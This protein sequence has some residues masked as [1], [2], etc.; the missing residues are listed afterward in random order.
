M[1]P[2]TASR[3][4][5]HDGATH[6]MYPRPMERI[7]RILLSAVGV[8]L[9][10]QTAYTASAMTGADSAVGHGHLAQAWWIASLAGL[11]GLARSISRSLKQRAHDPGNELAVFGWIAGGYVALELVER[12][13]D[14]IPA[15]S[16]FSEPVF[17]FGLAASPFVALALHRSVRTITSI[18]E[19]FGAV[20]PKPDWPAIPPSIPALRP[21]RVRVHSGHHPRSHPRRGPPSL[22]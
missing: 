4:N 14:G 8:L 18:V 13:V 7:D 6:G 16:L 19:A 2:A 22:N 11:L 12:V 3:V 15:A 1:P 20:E 10:H 9:V 17:W 21:I 5:R